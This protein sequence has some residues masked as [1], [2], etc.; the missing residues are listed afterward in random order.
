M[1]WRSPAA[2]NS[3]YGRYFVLLLVAALVLPILLASV[4]L[5]VS[6]MQDIEDRLVLVGPVYTREAEA[7]MR[8]FKLFIKEKYGKDI[9]INYIRPGGWP[10]V[11]DR[12]RAWKGKPDA[13][14]MFG[15]GPPAFEVLK[16]EGL[17]EKFVPKTADNLPD[18]AFDANIKDPEGVW[19]AFSLWFVTN[20]YNEKL[21]KKLRL[22]V[23]KTWDDLLKP[24]Y[25]GYIV[26]TL[27]YASGTMHE[28]TEIILQTRG[29]DAGWAYLRRLAVNLV[30]FSTGSTDTTLIVERGEAAIGVAQPQMNA[31]MARADGYPVKAIV[32]DVTILI[33]ESV[34]LL[35]NAPHPNLAKIFIEWLLSEDGQKYVLEG[36]YFP[37]MKDFYYSKYENEVEMAKHAKAATGVD[38][39][40]EI[41]G[42]KVLD[43]DLKLATERWDEVNNFYEK[44]IY[45]KWDEL[46]S[47]WTLIEQVNEEITAKKQTGADVSAAEAKIKEAISNFDAGKLAEARLAALSARDLLAAPPKVTVTET[48]EKTE[49][50]PEKPTVV[51]ETMVTTIVTTVMAPAP[52]RPPFELYA[53]II[54]AIALLGAAALYYRARSK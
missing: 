13:D 17:L 37:A 35:K 32:P 40:Y 20:I 15:A 53:A 49:M 51:R 27:P 5:P 25:R 45:R 11:V 26:H 16:K 30:R 4:P 38:N 19:Y 8:G 7:V 12:I 48:V 29:W 3:M 10:V 2:I 36:G 6:A 52:E 22:P 44:E 41:T 54:V 46:K 50:A 23:P 9:E 43:Y 14:V 31:M 39:F 1:S 18:R 42:V 21:M 34:A 33:P 28:T 24:I 47:T